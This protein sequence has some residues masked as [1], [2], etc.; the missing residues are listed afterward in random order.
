MSLDLFSYLFLFGWA[1]VLVAS[2]VCVRR[3]RGRWRAAA[4]VPWLFVPVWLLS[5]LLGL[6]VFQ[7][8]AFRMEII[9]FGV[10]GVLYMAGLIAAYPNRRR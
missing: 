7:S 8:T 4:A 9:V 3:W 5:A 1:F 2:A 10:V 6:P